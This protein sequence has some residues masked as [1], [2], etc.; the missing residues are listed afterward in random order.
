MSRTLTV[1]WQSTFFGGSQSDIALAMAVHPVSG[2]VYIAGHTDSADLPGRTG[3][4][5]G[6]GAGTDGF[7]ARLTPGLMATDAVPNAFSF[8]PRTNVPAASSQTSSPAQIT[9]I[10]AGPV[11]IAIHGGNY[12][13]YC[14][15]SAAVC[16]C[17]I[18]AFGTAP[19][20]IANNQ[21]ACVRQ[22]A[23]LL[24][25]AQANA[26]LVV[27]GGWA[28]FLV[29]TGTQVALPCTLD[30]D[31]NGTVDA[32]TDGL[33]IIRAMFGLTGTSVTNGAIAPGATR[34]TWAVVQAYLNGYCGAGFA[35]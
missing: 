7:V 18:R 30:V 32:L 21:Y 25:P 6:R 29:T 35:P 10:A 16:T 3:G 22:N 13:Q 11:P 34:T 31:G 5:L 33:I 1:P 24:T 4:A 17:D 15:S 14:V 26:T 12:A 28:N 9:G 2:A 27:G 20:T 19:A 8:P 23:P